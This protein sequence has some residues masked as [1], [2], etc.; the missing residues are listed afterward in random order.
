[1]LTSF[2]KFVLFLQNITLICP[3]NQ[4]FKMMQLYDCYDRKIPATKG[5]SVTM[6][7]YIFLAVYVLIILLVI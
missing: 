6:A 3:I 1:M 5:I 4:D 2:Y 7:T